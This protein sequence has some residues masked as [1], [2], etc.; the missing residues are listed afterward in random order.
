MYYYYYYTLPQVPPVIFPAIVCQPLPL[1]VQCDCC[2]EFICPLNCVG[3]LHRFLFF[4][5]YQEPSWAPWGPPAGQSQNQPGFR[6]A[7]TLY[8]NY[9]HESNETISMDGYTGPHPGYTWI[10]A[11]EETGGSEV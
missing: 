10:G 2:G 7:E 3:Q 6:D 11:Y 5:H 9:V 1:G 4:F 8:P